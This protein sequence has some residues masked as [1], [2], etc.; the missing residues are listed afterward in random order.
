MDAA[1]PP[2]SMKNQ[3][4]DLGN[5]IAMAGGISQEDQTVRSSRDN[6]TAINPSSINHNS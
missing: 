6:T 5:Q 2:E 3:F 4:S 1:L